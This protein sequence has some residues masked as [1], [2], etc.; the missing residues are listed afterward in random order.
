MAN[1]RWM[2]II[3]TGEYG[4]KEHYETSG[5]EVLEWL[6]DEDQIKLE[7]IKQDVAYL[8]AKS[9]ENEEKAKEKASKKKIKPAKE[10][11]PDANQS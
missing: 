9:K 3:A 7:Q 11:L 1:D 8:L 6:S 10:E 5:D 2:K 4:R